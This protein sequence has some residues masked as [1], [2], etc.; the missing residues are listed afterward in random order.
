MKDRKVLGTAADAKGKPLV[1]LVVDHEVEPGEKCKL[2]LAD[3]RGEPGWTV[4]IPEKVKITC[5]HGK[6][7]TTSVPIGGGVKR[8]R[9]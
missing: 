7:M 8:R 2:V 4:E 1:Y 3:P 6:S 5:P 9:R